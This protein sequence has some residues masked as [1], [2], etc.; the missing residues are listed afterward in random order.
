MYHLDY[1]NDEA[2]QL[3]DCGDLFYPYYLIINNYYNQLESEQKYIHLS[4]ASRPKK[5]K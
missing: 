2:T 1:F 3:P 4:Q 5:Y